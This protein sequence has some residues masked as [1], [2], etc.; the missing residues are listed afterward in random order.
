MEIAAC[1]ALVAGI[2]MLLFFAE[3]GYHHRQRAGPAT[4]AFI[5]PWSWLAGFRRVLGSG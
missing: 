3:R 5:A 2:T 1:L 4:V